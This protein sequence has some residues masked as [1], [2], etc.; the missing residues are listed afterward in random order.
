MLTFRVPKAS[1]SALLTKALRNKARRAHAGDPREGEVEDEGE[2]EDPLEHN[3]QQIYLM[4]HTPIWLHSKHKVPE[5]VVNGGMGV[6]PVAHK[7]EMD[8]DDEWGSMPQPYVRRHVADR[9]SV[10]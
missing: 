8:P 7:V 9:K 1:E 4:K 2:E 3:Q 6:R 10:V 5:Y